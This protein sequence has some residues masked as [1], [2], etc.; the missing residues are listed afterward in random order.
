MIACAICN[1]EREGAVKRCPICQSEETKLTDEAA[2]LLYCIDGRLRDSRGRGERGLRT[3][4]GRTKVDTEIHDLCRDLEE[5]GLIYLRRQGIDEDN[6]RQFY[7]WTA[8]D[9]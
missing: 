7:T 3:Y 8:T 1:T 4:P 2:A 6:G 5:A 9:V